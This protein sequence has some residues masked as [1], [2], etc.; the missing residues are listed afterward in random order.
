LPPRRSRRAWCRLALC[1]G[2]PGAPEVREGKVRLGHRGRT[3]AELLPL[4]LQLLKHSDLSDSQVQ[5]VW[6]DAVNQLFAEEQERAEAA[7]EAIKVEG[8]A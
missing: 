1:F 7:L 8:E 3:R 2:S 4:L 5:A 6:D